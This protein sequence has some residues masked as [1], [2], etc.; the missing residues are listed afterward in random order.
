MQKI[1][2]PNYGLPDELREKVIE[3]AKVAGAITASAE[4]QVGLSTVYKWLKDQREHGAKN[5][6]A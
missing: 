2:H 4:Y 1:Y 6:G 5:A 3:R